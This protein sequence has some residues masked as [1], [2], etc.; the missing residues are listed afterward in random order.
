ML[1]DVFTRRSTI[2]MLISILVERL[3]E[4]H[5]P[6]SNFH[7][8][9]HNDKERMNKNKIERTHYKK[10]KEK[11]RKEVRCDAAYLSGKLI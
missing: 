5:H 7:L 3:D 4:A 6:S 1:P 2:T 9:T 11:K 8:I 10:S